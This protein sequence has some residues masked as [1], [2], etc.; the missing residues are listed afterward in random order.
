[1]EWSFNHVFEFPSLSEVFSN[2]SCIPVNGSF[3]LTK[4]NVES[5]RSAQTKVKKDLMQF[6]R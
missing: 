2:D 3:L 1:M 4:G 6:W 5:I